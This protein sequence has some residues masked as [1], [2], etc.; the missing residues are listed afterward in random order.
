MPQYASLSLDRITFPAID[1]RLLELRGLPLTKRDLFVHKWAEWRELAGDIESLADFTARYDRLKASGRP[2]PEHDAEFRRA[3]NWLLQFIVA[4]DP[5][6]DATV[7]LIEVVDAATVVGLLLGKDGG[8]SV[9]E[10]IEFPERPEK[11]TG[12]PLPENVDGSTHLMAA[13]MA[14][15]EGDLDKAKQVASTVPYAELLA[16]L[17]EYNRIMEQSRKDAE[18][19]AKGG[20]PEDEDLKLSEDEL[21]ALAQEFYDDV[22]NLVRQQGVIENGESVGS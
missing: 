3:T 12:E 17:D 21:K 16:I 10:A 14:Y 9:I 19:A 2:N 22:D 1:G 18:K 8:K 11:A 15:C 5:M 4:T 6:D 20:K 13:L 7:P